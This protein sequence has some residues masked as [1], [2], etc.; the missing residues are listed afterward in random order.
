MVNE[1]D[2]NME[3]LSDESDSAAIDSKVTTL[4]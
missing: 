3:A 4:L 1:S 2:F